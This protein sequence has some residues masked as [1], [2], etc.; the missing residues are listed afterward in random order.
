MWQF[1]FTFIGWKG[2]FQRAAAWRARF[3]EAGLVVREVIPLGRSG[4]L[5]P[6]NVLYVLEAA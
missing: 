4:R 6:T 5:F 1:I 2:Q 3:A